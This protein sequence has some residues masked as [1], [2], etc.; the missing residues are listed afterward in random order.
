MSLQTRLPLVGLHVV[1]E[2]FHCLVSVMMLLCV[3]IHNK[4][5]KSSLLG[6]SRTKTMTCS[7]RN[8]PMERQTAR[9]IRPM[10]TPLT[11]RTTLRSQQ[12]AKA[13]VRQMHPARVC[14]GNGSPIKCALL[15]RT[16]QSMNEHE[17]WER[18]HCKLG[19]WLLVVYAF[20]PLISCRW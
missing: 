12:M 13:V 17:F 11:A 3:H 4:C 19:A 8:F 6:H 15:R 16:S 2:L 9:E 7:R 18:G 5:C 14:K 20:L 10:A 1:N